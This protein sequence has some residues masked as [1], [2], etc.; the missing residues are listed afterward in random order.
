MNF[1]EEISLLI[2][3]RYP[4]VMVDTIDEEYVLGQLR[5]VAQAQGLNFYS[6]SLSKGLR[7]AP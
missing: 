7:V 2:K 6:W 5:D 1:E 4:L 3:S